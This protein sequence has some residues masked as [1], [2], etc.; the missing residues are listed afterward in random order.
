VIA[1]LTAGI[2][3]L[4][5]VA[6]C[7]SNPPAD[8]EPSPT[9]APL[10]IE[11]LTALLPT[12]TQLPEGAHDVKRC[13]P[14]KD[15]WDGVE[16]SK[17]DFELEPPEDLANAD[18]E[19]RAN[20]FAFPESGTITVMVYPDKAAAEQAVATLRQ[21][22]EKKN[23]DFE[24]EADGTESRFTPGEKGHG[25]LTQVDRDGWTGFALSART[26]FSAPDG[27]MTNPGLEHVTHLRAGSMTVRVQVWLSAGDD[28]GATD[29]I[30]EDL[31]D[32]FMRRLEAA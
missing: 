6:A 13:G 3:A 27:D 30:A 22:A 19:R 12:D 26:T 7:G 17:V 14:A 5:L 4:V 32:G 16:A 9:V 20:G 15:C 18:R 31:L 23:G 2:A 28:T 8:P 11:Q 21:E 24:S 10:T 25:T 1:R 29:R